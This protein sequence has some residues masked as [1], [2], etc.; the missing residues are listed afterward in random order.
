MDLT[1]IIIVSIVFGSVITALFIIS[2]LVSKTLGARGSG[3]LNEEETQLMQELFYGMK[4]MEER[5][6][7]LETILLEKGRGG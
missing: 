2:N 5:V 4:K 6:E 3:K 7:S 1:A